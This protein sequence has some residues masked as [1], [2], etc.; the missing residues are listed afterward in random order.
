MRNISSVKAVIRDSEKTSNNYDMRNKSSV[1]VVIR[2]NLWQ[3][4]CDKSTICER[5]LTYDL[6]AR[7][8]SAVCYQFT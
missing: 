3:P 5:L 1:R 7:K 6:S 4:R 8:L 2:E